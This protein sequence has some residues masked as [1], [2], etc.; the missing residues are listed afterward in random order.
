MADDTQGVNEP[1]TETQ[2]VATPTT[3]QKTPG[4]EQ[5]PSNELPSEASERTKERFDTLT[6][7]LKEERQSREALERAFNTLKPKEDVKPETQAPIY[8][9]DT[10]LLN[11]Q[12]LTNVQ[13]RAQEAEKQA[14]ETKKQLDGYLEEQK[15]AAQVREDEEAFKAHPELD[16]KDKAFSKDLRDMTASLMLQSMIHP[17]DFGNK[18]LTHKEAG[19]KAKDLVAKL[20]GKV[21]EKAAQEAI[22]QLSPKE[23]AALDATGSHTQSSDDNIESLRR[24]TQRGDEDAIVARLH[25]INT[26]S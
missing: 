22:E 7:E 20:S 8:D 2:D 9:P 21:S 16:P 15:K 3:E 1:V 14:Q 17:E 23:Q 24:R 19:D 6:K 25:K 5:V 26:A 11:E 12:A 18:Q 4:S 10:G 13:L